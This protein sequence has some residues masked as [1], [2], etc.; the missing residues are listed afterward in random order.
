MDL[1]PKRKPSLNELF[2][3]KKL[4]HPNR[5]FWENFQDEFRSKALTSIVR[6]K[7]TS[8]AFLKFGAIFA[9]L[10]LSSASFVF[11]L[12]EQD[13]KT[14]NEIV[15]THTQIDKEEFP[16]DSESLI[17]LSLIQETEELRSFHSSNEPINEFIEQGL[18]VENSFLISSL[19]TSFHHRVLD[20]SIKITD[21]E[22]NQFSF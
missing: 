13:K 21:N 15:A 1:P 9:F 4:D 3:S 22:L 16:I 20:S 12:F 11:F 6:S 8:N 19:D 5:E 2:D 7:K 18:F 10:F 17:A 14:T